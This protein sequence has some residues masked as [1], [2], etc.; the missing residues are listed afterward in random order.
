[1]AQMGRISR[2]G[3]IGRGGGGALLTLMDNLVHYW[4]LDTDAVDYGSGGADLTASGA[5]VTYGPGYAA[6]DGTDTLSSGAGTFNPAG[7]FTLTGWVYFNSTGL[8]TIMGNP[9]AQ[10]GF[11]LASR[12]TK[13]EISGYNGTGFQ[14]G[15]KLY[16]QAGTTWYFVVAKYESATKVLSVDVDNTGTWGTV[17]LSAALN[18]PVGAR[19]FEGG[20]NSGGFGNLTGR[21]RHIGFWDG[22]ILTAAE[23]TTLYGGG[24]PFDPT[25]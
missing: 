19:I 18:Y 24:T 13:V 15:E 14:T 12:T 5:G 11:H 8:A 4:R 10:G 21:L 2:V 7:D 23:L 25:A 1:M 3:R 20:K 17:T 16:T 9:S 22:R 6:L